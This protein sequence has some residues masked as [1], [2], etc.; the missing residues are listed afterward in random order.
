MDS[1]DEV[2]VLDEA[3]SRGSGCLCWGDGNDI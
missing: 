2:R 3:R 1:D